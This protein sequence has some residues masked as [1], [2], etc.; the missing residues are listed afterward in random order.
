MQDIN[1]G[2]RKHPVSV[3]LPGGLTLSIT[4][5]ETLYPSI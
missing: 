5:R 2:L 1:F 4:A 3:L